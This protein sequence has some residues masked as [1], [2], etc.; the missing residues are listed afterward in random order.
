MFE[1]TRLQLTTWYLVILMTI[2]VLFSLA[3]YSSINAD[4]SRFEQM[5]VRFQRDLD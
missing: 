1:K 5:Q 3:V 4:L 2:S